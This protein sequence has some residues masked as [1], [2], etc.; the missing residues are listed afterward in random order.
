MEENTED[1]ENVCVWWGGGNTLDPRVHTSKIALGN[2]LMVLILTLHI[3]FDVKEKTALG[4]I[5]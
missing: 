3:Y 4:T 1:Q 2:I 5:L